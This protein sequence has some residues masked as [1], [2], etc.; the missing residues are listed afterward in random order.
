LAKASTHYK[1]NEKITRSADVREARK[2]HLPRCEPPGGIMITSIILG[3]KHGSDEIE[4]VAGPM[5]YGKGN[6]EFKQLI[7]SDGDGFEEMYLHEIQF[8]G[9]RK[10][11]TF[12]EGATKQAGTVGK[13][14]TD[15]GRDDAGVLLNPLPDTGEVDPEKRI[16]NRELL[17]NL[18]IDELKEVA[19]AENIDL[20]GC[21][22][23]AD[24]VNRIADHRRKQTTPL[25]DFTIEELK[26]IATEYGADVSDCKLKKDFVDTIAKHRQSTSD[27]GQQQTQE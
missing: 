2:G 18:T 14:A 26:Q 1:P 23:K 21:D 24:Y 25:D 15:P 12:P 3:R 6:A 5:P 10:R 7:L 9:G 16:R 11:A 22:L 4:L 17:D 20:S 8:N 27:G 13:V 19:A